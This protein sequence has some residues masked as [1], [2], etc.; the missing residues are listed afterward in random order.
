MRR[1]GTNGRTRTKVLRKK[2]QNRYLRTPW[3]KESSRARLI[4]LLAVVLCA[5]A[6]PAFALNEPQIVSTFPDVEGAARH[7][8]VEKVLATYD[9]DL[10]EA[11]SGF[12]LFDNTMT[13]VAGF[14]H[15]AGARSQTGGFRTAA[16]HPDEFLSEAKSPYTAKVKAR[17]A[18][19]ADPAHTT[20]RFWI[21]DTPPATPLLTAPVDGS[22]DRGQPVIARGTGDPGSRV[23]VVEGTV[24]VGEDEVNQFGNFTIALNYSHEDGV[25]HS[26]WAHAVDRPGNTSPPT[27]LV[28]FEH[29]SIARI[30]LISFPLESSSHN[31]TT[32]TV[33]GEGS[34]GTTITLTENGSPFTSA[35]VEPNA[36]WSAPWTFSAGTHSITASTVDDGNSTVRTFTVDLSA[37][38]APVILSPAAGAQL[39]DANV[40]ITGTAEPN[41]NVRI[42]QGSVLRATTPAS[43]A[44]GWSVTLP[45]SDG[46]H[47]ISATVVD[48]AGNIGPSVSRSFVVD[49][50]AP[51]MPVITSPVNGAFVNVNPVPIS[52]S[53]EEGSTVKIYEGTVLIGT[54]TAA[55][56]GTWSTAITFTQ[57][58]HSI[59]AVTVDGAQN[60]GPS[61]PY[62]SFTVDTTAP[63]APVITAPAP[64]STVPTASVTITGTAEPG[65]SVF[66]K[67]GL[68]TIA[69]T[70]ANGA[71]DWSVVVAF[72]NGSH[73]IT[74][75]AMDAATNLSAPSPPVTFTVSASGDTTP[76]GAPTI[77]NPADSSLQ[78]AFVSF[79]GIAE[80]GSTVRI[81][82][83]AVQ[84]VSGTAD[85]GGNWRVGATFLTGSHTV[86]ATASDVAGNVGVASAP[87]TF[88]V[89]AQAPEIWLTTA[90]GA[91]FLPLQPAVIAGGARDNLGVDRIVVEYR[92]LRGELVLNA[93]A[94]TCGGCPGSPV[95]WEA[96]PVL[97]P[98]IYSAKAFAVDLAGNRSP[99]ASLG[100]YRL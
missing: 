49:T 94:N 32:L 80:P 48:A 100:F 47:T 81:F 95:T 6:A 35:T 3:R 77:V 29:D 89:D 86:T 25:F 42:R 45:F 55:G 64:S 84:R 46:A 12:Q 9:R 8:D 19:P 26:I 61:S 18:V 37:P 79:T 78:P 30:P 67:E 17:A 99:A 91:L 97:T 24:R 96:R 36:R 39:N 43:G 1:N 74:A 62:T 92:D 88:S 83:G 65:A 68:A 52:G 63:G 50:A 59:T 82:E 34:P 40:T 10:D 2:R 22:V 21:D 51:P 76:P 13:P 98:G 14:F 44:G 28:T 53:A 56:S 90:G 87:R 60:A 38:G 5:T 73:T 72:G 57:A 33:T 16:F 85:G 93:P 20:W 58:A 66:V 54:A 11:N 70:G 27:P 75:Y 23:V 71:G 7:G 4:V 69:S 15:L 31:T 41:A